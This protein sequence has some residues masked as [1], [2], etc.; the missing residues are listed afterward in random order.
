M[1]STYDWKSTWCFVSEIDFLPMPSNEATLILFLICASTLHRT[2][3][4]SNSTE[5][6]SEFQRYFSLYIKEVVVWMKKITIGKLK[7]W[8]IWCI[9][10]CF[11]YKYV[12]IVCC[13]CA[14]YMYYVICRYLYTNNITHY[15]NY[16]GFLLTHHIFCY[17]KLKWRAST[18]YKEKL[19]AAIIKFK[20]K[21]MVLSS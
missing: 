9:L 4:V 2:N 3:Q 14:T 1:F 12:H 10:D 19:F 8:Y 5:S 21:Y 7:I 13:Y 17:I 16:V 6:F 15:S 18:Q 20:L 11:V